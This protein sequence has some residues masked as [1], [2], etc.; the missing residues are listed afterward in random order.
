MLSMFNATEL[1]ASSSSMVSETKVESP[2]ENPTPSPTGTDHSSSSYFSSIPLLLKRDAPEEVDSDLQPK[3][4]KRRRKPD[5]KDVVRLL[6]ES[7]EAPQLFLAPSLV[8]ASPLTES[9]EEATSQMET[10]KPEIPTIRLSPEDMELLKQEQAAQNESSL[11]MIGTPYG[12]AVRTIDNGKLAC[13]TPGCDGSGHQTGLYTHHRSLSGCPRRPNKNTIQLLSLQQDTVLHCQTP[14][15]DGKGHVNSSRNSHRSLSGCPIAHQQKLA[16]KSR[17]FQQRQSGSSRQSSIASPNTLANS[18]SPES[19]SNSAP[20]NLVNHP[21]ANLL[22]AS[23]ATMFAQ[24]Q[25]H[26]QSAAIQR[27]LGHTFTNGFPAVVPAEKS[28]EQPLDLRLKNRESDSENNREKCDLV[29]VS[30]RLQATTRRPQV[31]ATLRLAS[32]T[33]SSSSAEL[34]VVTEVLQ[35]QLCQTTKTVHVVGEFAE[36]VREPQLFVGPASCLSTQLPKQHASTTPVR[37]LPFLGPCQQC[38]RKVAVDSTS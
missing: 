27:L 14:G 18:S 16:R 22:S 13:P 15:C 17:Q 31:P 1:A 35:R 20:G 4:A 36:S 9:Q 28:E 10:L 8:A 23:P 25:N 2:V 32:A 33:T 34:R 26:L 38:R 3:P 29:E 21:L 30:S 12:T 7:E 5:S 11:S 19:P 6:E 37:Q 24:Q